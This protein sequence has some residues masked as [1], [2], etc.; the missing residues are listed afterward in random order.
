[1]TFEKF[2]VEL[3][4]CVLH[5]NISFIRWTKNK[6]RLPSFEIDSQKTTKLNLAFWRQHQQLLISSILMLC[7]V[8]IEQRRRNKLHLVVFEFDSESS[9]RYYSLS[10]FTFVL[11]THIQHWTNTN[12]N[13]T[14]IKA[15][16]FRNVYI[17]ITNSRFQS[18]HS[19]G[20]FLFNVIAVDLLCARWFFQILYR[21]KS[22]Q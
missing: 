4:D 15:I 18:N 13:T 3:K 1:M 12:T 11:Y 7:S 20:Y 6:E 10:S 5:L 17:F 22:I 16:S 14:S 9:F 19:F 21:S 2:I 8:F